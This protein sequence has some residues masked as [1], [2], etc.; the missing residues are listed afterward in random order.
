VNVDDAR[1]LANADLSAERLY[2]QG[3]F[4]VTAAV[5]N[6]A[7]LRNGAVP[8]T[9]VVV[10]YPSASTPPQQ[11][12]QVNRSGDRPFLITNIRKTSDGQINIYV[13]EVT[14]P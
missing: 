6:S 10:Q 12:E 8:N 14:S 4:N 7:V 5:G 2:L 3:D 11:G 1:A 13:R 9:R